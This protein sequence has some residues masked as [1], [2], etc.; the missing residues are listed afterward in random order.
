MDPQEE[1]LRVGV[2]PGGENWGVEVKANW[3]TLSLADGTAS[4]QIETA[5]GD[6]RKFYA[7]MR[8]AILEGVPLEITPQQSLATMRV[9]ELAQQSSREGRT[10]PW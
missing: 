4:K 5:V 6:Y 9:L 1:P 3:G 10:I 2:D 8:D 7:M